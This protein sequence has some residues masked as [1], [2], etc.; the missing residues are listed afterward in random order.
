MDKPFLM[1]GTETVNHCTAP[2]GNIPLFVAPFIMFVGCA[3][4]SSAPREDSTA[5]GAVISPWVTHLCFEQSFSC[6]R[7][8]MT[9]LQS[10]QPSWEPALTVR[11]KGE[12]R[13]V[14]FVVFCTPLF[15]EIMPSLFLA[16][17]FCSP[18]QSRR[19]DLTVNL[20]VLYY[21]F[22][23]V[24][25]DIKASVMAAKRTPSILKRREIWAF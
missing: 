13:N 21:H 14:A 18:L 16:R 15:Q 5:L 22:L 2:G 10:W 3:D 12:N 9:E 6:P 19:G 17:S 7:F 25:C 1:P 20:C 11:I 8:G 24:C 23:L 4:E